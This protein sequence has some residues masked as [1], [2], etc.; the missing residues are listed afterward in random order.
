MIVAILFSA[1]VVL[2]PTDGHG[3]TAGDLQDYRESAAE[4]GR[5]ADAHV[6]LALWCESRGLAAE[7][8]KHLT[9]AVLI[10]PENQAARG[11][12][13]M[14]A[15]DGKWVRPEDVRSKLE[16]DPRAQA[17][18]REYLERR[19]SSPDTAEAHHRLARWCNQN[20]LDAQASAHYQAV[21]RLEPTR[22][23]VWKKLGYRRSD[24]R[25][26]R[27]EDLRVEKAEAE[28]R[29]LAVRRW[30]PILEKLR[31]Q[32]TAKDP[33]TRA[34]AASALDAIAEAS[35]V[36]TLWAVFVR[37][38]ARLQRRLAETLARID[39]RSASLA[40][41]ELA[42]F[43]PIA[44]VRGLAAQL[45][46][47]RDPRDYL[48]PLLDLIHKPFKYT[49]NP[50]VGSGTRGGLFAEGES[51]NIERIYNLPA[52]DPARMP[53]RIFTD[54]IPLQAAAL[55]FLPEALSWASAVQAPT[56]P[57]A[58]PAIPGLSGPAAGLLAPAL[59]PKPS[60]L[61]DPLVQSAVQQDQQIAIALEEDRARV[62][63]ARQ[64]LSEDVASIERRNRAIVD[65]NDR[66]LPL[67]K[68]ATGQDFGDAGDSWKGWWSDQL[69]YAY[70]S[71]QSETKPTYTEVIAYE[72]P[73]L[74][75]QTGSCF[76]AGTPVH[77]MAGLV[78]IEAVRV[79]DLVLSQDVRTGAVTYKPV[80][81]THHNPPAA[82]VKLTIGAE[83]V[84]ATGIHR[85][86]RASWGWTM[87]RDLRV[88][89]VVRVMGGTQLVAAIEP[90]LA[91]PVYN[92]DV[93]DNLDFFVGRNGFLVHDFSI[94][95]EPTRPFDAVGATGLEVA[96][97][98]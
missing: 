98:R 27:P 4:L 54:D 25:W 18:L 79:G 75:V 42:V 89:D 23:S 22:E 93:A 91:R 35:A 8:L 16:N 43:S 6:R 21:V 50:I 26:A 47:R 60:P 2:Q 17:L 37:D 87:A 94:V 71:S 73:R 88:G 39:G 3:P 53:R 69:G 68:K 11:L 44:E 9:R 14:I 83:T 34:K 59:V 95:R 48:D 55:P 41:A 92:L 28:A 82:T 32:C 38:D 5:D 85:F 12:L 74:T 58:L 36:P 77:T 10:D 57:P 84:T 72:V 15:R 52:I 1:A 70:R 96:S 90:G 33:Q 20:G 7:R 13:G 76:V 24:G 46:D 63:Q 49:V 64:R 40:L 81:V 80:L 67:V 97:G 65:L 78:P 30:K 19:T 29:R 51:F 56:P 45:L 61:A 62:E 31:D 66:I 86:W